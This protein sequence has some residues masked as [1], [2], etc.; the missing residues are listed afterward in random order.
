MGGGYSDHA[1]KEQNWEYRRLGR[2]GKQFAVFCRGTGNQGH[3]GLLYNFYNRRKLLL[4][5]QLIGRTYSQITL[6]FGKLI[7]SAACALL[8]VLVRDEEVA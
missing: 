7:L 8:W 5:D 4:F 6:K 3:L 2:D 1:G